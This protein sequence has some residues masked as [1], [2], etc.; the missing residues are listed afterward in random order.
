[1]IAITTKT[2]CLLLLL[3]STTSASASY[4]ETTLTKYYTISPRIS[5]DISRELNWRSP[6]REH[7]V[8]YHG[9]TDWN[10][11]WNYKVQQVPRGCVINNIQTRIEIK[12]TLPTLDERITD[13]KTIDRFNTFNQALTKHEH[14]HGANGLKAANEIDTALHSIAPQRNCRQLDRYANQLGH[15]I[16]QK[17][18]D[19]D[20]EYDRST[21]N[22][23]TEGAYIQ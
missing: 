6:I 14:N 20:N 9:H 13:K 10:I 3:L 7:G 23:R 22:G 12:Y 5:Q 16:I 2:T 21:R 4:L 15:G 8:T 1:M 18:I 19:I 17:Y 11:S